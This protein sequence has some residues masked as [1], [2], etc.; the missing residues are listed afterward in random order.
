M[1]SDFQPGEDRQAY[2]VPLEDLPEGVTAIQFPE[3]GCSL[4]E[5]SAFFGSLE[6]SLQE[7]CSEQ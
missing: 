6:S 1:T 5:M 4:E 3:K 2:A 7:A